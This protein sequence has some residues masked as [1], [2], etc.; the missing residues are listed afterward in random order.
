[1]HR[2]LGPLVLAAALAAVT[3]TVAAGPAQGAARVGVAGVHS[4]QPLHTSSPPFEAAF[5]GITAR[6]VTCR[7]VRRLLRRYGHRPPGWKC[8]T[9]D[10]PAVTC[11][12]GRARYHYRFDAAGP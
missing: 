9:Q 6:N 12:R 1:M 5:F 3:P 8:R 4:C 2:M 10:G 7:R 11:R